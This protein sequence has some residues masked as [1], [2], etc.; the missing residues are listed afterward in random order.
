MG[1]E[2]RKY[3]EFSQPSITGVNLIDTADISHKSWEITKWWMVGY[4]AEQ[5]MDMIFLDE[6]QV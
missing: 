1:V 3:G 5:L 2:A 6:L 4:K